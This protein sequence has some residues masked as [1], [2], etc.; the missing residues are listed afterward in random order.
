VLSVDGWENIAPERDPF[1]LVSNHSSRRETLYLTAVLLL[2]RR[3]CPVRFL[4]DWNFRLIPGVGLLYDR[5][6]AITLTG[7]PAR[8]RF[9]NRLKPWFEPAM[10]P[11]EEARKHLKRGGS[12]GIFPEGTV[13][14]DGNRLLRGR[15]GAARL[16]LEA[17]VPVV[18]MGIRFARR[19]PGTGATDSTS[20]MSI[21]FGTPIDP[22]NG[23][24][25]RVSSSAVND[26]HARLM[27]EI[28]LLC[29]KRWEGR[30]RHN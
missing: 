22:P 11:F 5:S 16:S 27:G 26:W 4:A 7:K 29:G 14:R 9:L 17:G 24:S 3:G 13:N 2:A 1:L 19:D 25:S 8:P 18:P 10:P 28:G 6:G 12:I 15:R 20:P 21:R 23:A 30:R